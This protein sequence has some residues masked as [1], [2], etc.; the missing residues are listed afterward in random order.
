MSAALN[1]GGH[2]GAYSRQEG[3][4]SHSR[5]EMVPRPMLGRAEPP[6]L[7]A[8]RLEENGA[9]P[10]SPGAGGRGRGQGSDCDL[11]LLE[12]RRGSRTLCS[13]Q[14]GFLLALAGRLLQQTS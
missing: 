6:E 14:T 13:E 2:P 10:C 4:R 12:G 11:G 8:S 9:W 7:L 3:A 1:R 5:G